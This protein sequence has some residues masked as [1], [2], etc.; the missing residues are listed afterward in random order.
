MG[1]AGLFSTTSNTNLQ[2]INQQIGQSGAGSFGI[3]GGIQTVAGSGANSRAGDIN[4]TSSNPEVAIAAINSS[5]QSSLKTLEALQSVGDKFA[6]IAQTAV[7]GAQNTALNAIP[8]TPEQIAAGHS[9]A[10]L[11]DYIPVGIAALIGVGLL[12]YFIK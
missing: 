2:T 7:A 12:I 5:Q 1:F 11:A 9:Q 10:G 4:I 6:G 3:S 8:L